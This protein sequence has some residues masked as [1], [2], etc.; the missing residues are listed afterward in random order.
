[1]ADRLRYLRSARDLI[2][3]VFEKS[4]HGAT[5]GLLL[6]RESSVLRHL[7]MLEIGEKERARRLGESVR[8]ATRAVKESREAVTLLEEGLAEWAYARYE[9]TDEKYASRLRN[10]EKSLIS[11]QLDEF[12]PAQLARTSFYRLTFR[13]LDACERFPRSMQ[14]ARNVRRV[15]R[16]SYIYAEAAIQLWYGGYPPDVTAEHI[17]EARS[18]LEAGI[19]AGYRNARLIVALAYLR[20]I[21]EGAAAGATVLSDICG[22][23]AGV[24]WDEAL[25]LAASPDQT[26]LVN[27]GFALG[28]DQS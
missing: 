9:S 22:E 18:L 20:A 5:R 13:P 24:A 8:C 21:T 19:G 16:E 26:D 28:L 14:G 6:S 1:P 2:D 11:E 15:L 17:G 23:K 12:E 27:L 10:A 3:G 4:G 7:S 25:R